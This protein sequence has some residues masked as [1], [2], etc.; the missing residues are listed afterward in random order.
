MSESQRVPIA[1]SIMQ[2]SLTTLSPDDTFFDAIRTFLKHRISGAPVVGEDGELLGICSELDCL[3][4]LAS[5]EYYRD[6]HQAEG[7]VRSMMSTEYHSVAP[8]T[9]IYTLAQLF[10]KHNVR[11]LPVIEN[12]ELI[13]QLSRR[14]VLRAMEKFG[15]S[16]VARRRYPDYREPASDVGARRGS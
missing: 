9:D 6:D 10:V 16:R 2:K 11:R 3:K 5:G 13:G 1:R 12:G 7:T 14:D 4:V 15:A 8:H